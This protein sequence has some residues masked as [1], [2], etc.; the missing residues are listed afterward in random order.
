MHS[1]FVLGHMKTLPQLVHSFKMFAICG[2]FFVDVPSQS[3]ALLC[4]QTLPNLLD[5]FNII[6]SN[7]LNIY[8]SFENDSN[9]RNAS[10]IMHVQILFIILSIKLLNII[11]YIKYF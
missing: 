1:V 9:A 6:S 11:Y 7:I 3:S 4:F 10:R 2:S 5:Y 8:F